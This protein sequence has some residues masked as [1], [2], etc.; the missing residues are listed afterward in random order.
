MTLS[1]EELIR[2]SR[3]L[4]IPG[5]GPEGQERLKAARVAVVGA[6]GLGNIVMAYLAGAGVGEIGVF[7]FGPVELSNLHRQ[8]VYGTDDVGKLKTGL[9]ARKLAEIN[10]GIR[11]NTREGLLT[12]GNMSGAL[13]GYDYIAD[14]TDNFTARAAINRACLELGK[15]YVHAAVYQFEGQLTVF[16]PGRGACLAC[17]CPRTEDAEAQVCAEAGVMGPAAGA[18]ASMQALEV[19][20]L[21]LGFETL[22]DRFVMLDFRL[23]GFTVAELKRR[24]DCPVCG[25]RASADRAFLK[26]VEP[27]YITPEALRDK[28]S[29]PR[30]PRLLDLRYE[31]EHDL[32]HIAGDEWVDH[33]E[34]LRTGAGL[35]QQEEI[36]LYCKGRSK[37]VAAW[38]ALKAGG[39]TDVSVLEGGLDAWS[40][41][42]DRTLTRY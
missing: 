30:P 12:S 42:I 13:A 11:V 31:W 3:Q 4:V 35:G 25:A 36:V 40:G 34:L 27:D 19:L 18:V 32:V 39:F 17:L 37:A 6:G 24:E 21:I 33:E 5:V 14:C 2:Y 23:G 26:S 29:G 10:P 41:R 1:K 9:A 7:D 38:R 22:R 20:K 16:S 15:T 28:L 8:F